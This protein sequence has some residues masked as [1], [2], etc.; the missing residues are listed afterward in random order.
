CGRG[1]GPGAP[2]PAAAGPAWRAIPASARL[3]YDNSGG[4][5]DSLR[6]VIRDQAAF[7]AAWSQATSTQSAP[8]APPTVDFNREM[9]LLVAA[10]RKTP[11]EQIRVDSLVTQRAPGG[12]PNTFF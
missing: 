7:S 1:G 4:I 11:E 3:Y 12:G 9:V 6:V 8:P 10:G 5:R 2:S